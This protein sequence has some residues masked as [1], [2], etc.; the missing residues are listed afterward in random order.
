[1]S[2]EPQTAPVTEVSTS[3]DSASSSSTSSTLEL[4]CLIDN[5]QVGGIIGKAGAN[6]K[7]IREESGAYVSIVKNDFNRQAH[8]RIMILKGQVPAISKATALVAQSLVETNTS[9]RDNANNNNNPNNN[10]SPDIVSLKLL[11]HKNGVG[12]IIGKQGALIRDTQTETGARVQVSNDLLPQS[13]EKAVTISGTPEQVQK[14]MEKIATQLKEN[15]IKPGTKH[16]PYTPGAQMY[17]PPQFQHA[18]YNNPPMSMYPPSMQHM[19]HGMMR[20]P[21]SIGVPSTQKIAIPTVCAGCV[22]GKN[23]TVIKDL[24]A[25]SGTNISI[26]DPDPNTPQE[27][28]V[29]I[30]GSPQGINH[31]IHLIKQ[32]VEQYQPNQN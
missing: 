2:S 17:P 23:G 22:I 19:Q 7:R 15:P 5:N 27:R 8:E 16:Y 18:P 13:T 4:R 32:L 25:Q 20:A 24:R 6:V 14:A 12:C 29:T 1:M 26:A 30:I 31:A 11:V 9:R 21:A 3:S 10:S 28:V